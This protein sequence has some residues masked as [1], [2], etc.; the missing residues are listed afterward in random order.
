M[1]NGTVIPGQWRNKPSGSQKQRRA[2]FRSCAERVRQKP[3][4]THRAHIAVVDIGQR[5]GGANARCH[6][7]LWSLYDSPERCSLTV[8]RAAHRGSG[9]GGVV[10]VD[11]VVV[12]EFDD[13]MS[14]VDANDALPTAA[15]EES[16]PS[17][18]W[19]RHEYRPPGQP[20]DGKTDST[21]SG[22]TSSESFPADGAASLD[23]VKTKFDFEV[24]LASK[25][26]PEAE[27][28]RADAEAEFYRQE[29]K[30]SKALASMHV[31]EK[32]KIAA[33]ADF[34]V[35][36]HRQAIAKTEMLQE[37]KKLFVEQH[38]MEALKRRLL[39]L[40]IRKIKRDQGTDVH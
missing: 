20:L 33:I 10:D 24:F 19:E 17:F 35:E 2:L 21:A 27:E 9:Q 37:H 31:E 14:E 15:A 23:D 25:R 5:G 1:D 3:G 26:K 40:E 18:F 8:Y 29:T 6:G 28:R 11:D 7:L 22:K 39:Q 30:R 4:R 13:V 38:K 36:E 34:H 16:S 32:F 12:E